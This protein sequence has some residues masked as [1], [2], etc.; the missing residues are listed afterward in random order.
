MATYHE[1]PAHA[2]GSLPITLP[3]KLSG[4]DPLLAQV[5]SVL[6]TNKPILIYG[7]SGI[8]KTALAGAL[9]SAYT[10]LPGGALWLNVDDSPLEELIVRVGRAYNIPEIMSSDTPLGMVGAVASTLTANK[11]LI[12]LDGRHNAQATSSFISRCAANLPVMIV[13]RD[14]LPGW[15]ALEL[16]QL[17]AAPSIAMLRQAAALGDDAFEDELDE[18]ASILDYIPFALSVAGGTMRT[19]RQSPADYLKAFEQIPTSAGATPQLLALT[20]GFRALNN[21]LQGVM[22]V[23]GA[24]FTGG[25]SAE[26]LSM[27]SG[28]PQETITQVMTLLDQANLVEKS[29]RYD[30][31]YYQLH[32]IT[33]AFAE[34]WLRGSGRLETLQAKVR[35]TVLAYAQK[36]SADTPA[37]H[38]K[39]ATEMEQ[40]MAVAQWSANKGDRDLANQLVVSLM[41]AGDFINE[42]GYVYELLNLR[43]FASSFTT[44][45][46]AYPTPTR[47]EDALAETEAVL[48]DEADDFEDDDFE[49]EDFEDDDDFE[50]E[51]DELDDDGGPD[52][53][54]D[55]EDELDDDDAGAVFAPTSAP[56]SVPG[57]SAA[58][59]DELARLQT[60]LREA[61]AEDNPVR[62]VELHAQIGD[63]QVRRGMENEAISSYSEALTGYEQLEDAVGTLNVLDKLAT[64]MAK[65]E[66][67]SAAVLH[68]TRGIKLADELGDPDTKMFLLVALGD[69]RQQLGE[70]AE[71]VGAFSNALEIARTE[72]DAQNE[73]LILF[74]LGYAQ[75]DN[76]DADTASETWEQA[77]KLFR[78]QNKR[79]YEG[80]V[81]GGLGAAYGELGRWEEAINFHTS[82]LY[83]AREVQ[84][85]EE[86]GLELSNLGYASV[87]ANQLG[88]AVTHYRQALHLA[89]QANDRDNIVSN[90][91]DLARLLVESRRHLDIAELLVDDAMALDSSNRDLSRI[92][93]R[94]QQDRLKATTDG[95]VQLTI[96][97]TSKDYA[98]NAYKL[99][100]A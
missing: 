26:L 5:Y 31:P 44:A 61:K 6:K 95:V 85:K 34:T 88:Q 92:K 15:P 59:N 40:I 9:A 87:Q 48:D 64:L 39:L 81:L 42:R 29:E 38:D 7:A 45:F 8:G 53:L 99:L 78:T 12:V 4:R 70:S 75:L 58:P 27:L 73:A 36:Y 65:T 19:A 50:D 18:L 54:L 62:E 35:D 97:G 49:D 89:Y 100:E 33:R 51:D 76:S 24:T 47:P 74:K 3:P 83:I 67:S 57:L 13:S 72:G 16:K 60:S 1:A 37:A 96:N 46:P 98:A 43:Q 10:E 11:P 2:A 52:S 71:A 41:Q 84:D 30:A 23:L 56:P 28:A 55:L 77:L 25:A 22:L 86:E 79:A 17:E 68:A 66:N 14:A 20:I 80:R 91:L 21:A 93:D 69:A 63:L 32:E 94:I 82:A 90:I